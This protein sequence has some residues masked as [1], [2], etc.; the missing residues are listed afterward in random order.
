MQTSFQVFGVLESPEF[1]RIS[2]AFRPVIKGEKDDSGSQHL[3]TENGTSQKSPLLQA[4]SSKAVN[5]S[6]AEAQ[7]WAVQVDFLGWWRCRCVFCLDVNGMC[8]LI[9]IVNRPSD[10]SMRGEILWLGF[11]VQTLFLTI[12]P[13]CCRCLQH[14]KGVRSGCQGGQALRTVTLTLDLPLGRVMEMQVSVIRHCSLRVAQS[15]PG[16]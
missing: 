3:I 6:Q 11:C 14:L 8:S 5:G 4:F 10:V 1:S 16:G 13:P 2:S 9:S 12:F 15:K 7:V